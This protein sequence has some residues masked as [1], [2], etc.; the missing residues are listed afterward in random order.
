MVTHPWESSFSKTLAPE[1]E[2]KKSCQVFFVFENSRLWCFM[3]LFNI[4]II[5]IIIIISNIIIIT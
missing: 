5:I 4:I 3:G 2:H 1:R